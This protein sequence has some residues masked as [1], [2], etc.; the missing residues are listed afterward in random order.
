VNFAVYTVYGGLQL[1][2]SW[3]VKNCKWGFDGATIKLWVGGGYE[4][5]VEI[6]AEFLRWI[7]G[8]AS[9]EPLEAEGYFTISISSATIQLDQHLKFKSIQELLITVEL[10]GDT[11]VKIGSNV[12]ISLHAGASITEGY[13]NNDFYALFKIGVDGTGEVSILNRTISVSGGVGFKLEWNGWDWVRKPY[14]DPS[15]TVYTIINHDIPLE[16]PSL[17]DTS[18]SNSYA[19]SLVSMGEDA[20]ASWI[21]YDDSGIHIVYSQYHNGVWSPAETLPFGNGSYALTITVGFNGRPGV[22]VI[23]APSMQ[24]A[25]DLDQLIDATYNTTIYYSERTGGEWTASKD[26]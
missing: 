26:R 20:G 22:F 23:D 16:Y 11:E 7:P 6:P 15:V 4:V 8:H 2:G 19:P 18:V 21:M 14:N 17:T 25:Q 12:K 10:A 5:K 1:S 13:K 3:S 24:G 9:D